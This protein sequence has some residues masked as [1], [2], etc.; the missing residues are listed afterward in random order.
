MRGI[1][2]LLAA[3][4]IGYA[5]RR[6]RPRN[7]AATPAS[8]T[9]SIAVPPACGASEADSRHLAEKFEHV[10]DRV[11]AQV[12]A[13][14]GLSAAVLGAIIAVY[15]LFVDKADVY[16]PALLTLAIPAALLYDNIEDRIGF[17]PDPRSFESA[18]RMSPAV[19]LESLVKDEKAFIERNT[20]VRRNKRRTFYRSL[21][22]LAVAC[23][24]ATLCKG[25]NAHG[26]IDAKIHQMAGWLGTATGTAAPLVPKLHLRGR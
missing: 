24:A 3:A 1:G 14:D 11:I 10:N 5:L 21:H 7:L 18:Y 9:A 25:Y 20:V 15:V 23:L 19:A 4:A 16:W 8:S 13:W 22:W 6:R 2:S 17:S 26:E 12:R